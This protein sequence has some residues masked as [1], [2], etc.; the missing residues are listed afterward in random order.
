MSYNG[1]SDPILF[2]IKVQKL[3]SKAVK[4]GINVPEQIICENIVKK[5][6]YEYK[7][8][9][10]QYLLNHDHIELSSILTSIGK[11]HNKRVRQDTTSTVTPTT[12]THHYSNH[13]PTSNHR[14]NNQYNRKPHPSYNNYHHQQSNKPSFK[15]KNFTN[16]KPNT[17]SA[18]HTKKHANAI[19]VQEGQQVTEPSA[20]EE[21]S[22]SPSPPFNSPDK[23]QLSED[24]PQSHIHTL[25]QIQ[26]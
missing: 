2:S 7:P 26:I 17:A 10:D 4:F 23:Q 5:L 22:T 1:T 16:H 18:D 6:P 24:P 13:Q 14:Q 20:N 9:Q 15:F 3:L 19:T 12:N 8:I 25:R 21:A 11:I